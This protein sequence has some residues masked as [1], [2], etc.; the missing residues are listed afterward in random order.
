MINRLSTCKKLEQYNSET[1]YVTL[2]TQ[3][4]SHCISSKENTS[5]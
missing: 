2:G 4:P 1:V 3:L 5:I